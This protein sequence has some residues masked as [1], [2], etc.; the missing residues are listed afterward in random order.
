MEYDHRKKHLF[1]IFIGIWLIFGDCRHFELNARKN[2]EE[3]L[4]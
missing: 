2:R 3:L 1:D 4:H